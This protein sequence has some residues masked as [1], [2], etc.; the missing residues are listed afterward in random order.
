VATAKEQGMSREDTHALVR[1]YP[2]AIEKWTTDWRISNDVDRIW[3]K[4]K[5]PDQIDKTFIVEE[6]DGSDQPELMFHTLGSLI[7]RVA[8]APAPQYLFEG[9][10]SEGDYG[11]ISAEDKAGKSLVMLD[12]GV[13]AASG[14]A[15]MGRFACIT[16]GPVILC[17]GE[18]TERKQVRRIL[19]IGRQK[20]LTDAQI[21]A[22]PIHIL[23]DVPQ[24]KDQDH[25]AELE[26]KIRQVK[27]VLVEIDPF[28]LAASGVDFA[29]LSDVGQALKPVQT[30]TQRYNSALMLSHHW[31]KTGNGDSISRTSGVGLTAWGR[32]LIGIKIEKESMDPVTRKTCVL[33]TWSVKGD[34]VMTEDFSVE[35]TVWVD[36]PADLT[37]DMHYELT[38]PDDNT[39]KRAKPLQN[40]PTMEKIS[41]ILALNLDGLGIRAIMREMKEITGRQMSTKTATICLDQLVLHGYITEGKPEGKGRI[42]PYLHVKPFTV[43]AFKEENPDIRDAPPRPGRTPA[44]ERD[45][46]FASARSG[47]RR[48]R[49]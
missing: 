23:L 49:G 32:F 42:K 5:G 24:V 25:I 26:E 29:K 7:D 47:P 28:Y 9:I 19:A 6:D 36:D 21:K 2:P 11:I 46:D 33:Q 12:A 45:L 22:L 13:S 8:S 34:E 20:G 31:N 17:L 41:G 37:S 48:S 1:T 4:S 44:S 27:P 14:T 30:V 40:M 35:R 38:L 10:I 15:W 3:Q 18:G 16:P 39:V 43:A